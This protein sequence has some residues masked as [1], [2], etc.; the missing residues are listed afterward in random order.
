M[1]PG[2]QMKMNRAP[3]SVTVLAAALR[4]PLMH[5]LLIGG[6]L[7]L[8]YQ[9]H[10]P[11][12]FQ[13]KN[14]ILVT[15]DDVARL[16]AGFAQ[17]WQRKPTSPEMD[18]LI[19]NFVREE[20]YYREAKAMGLDQDDIAVRRRL[21]QKLEFIL[22]DVAGQV[23]PGD[24]QLRAFMALSPQKYMY[25]PR[26]S[27]RQI[28]INPGLHGD[29][30]E[31]DI[32]QLI[33][34]LKSESAGEG[35]Q[36]TEGDPSLLPQMVGNWSRSAVANE[37]GEEFVQALEKMDRGSW[38]GLIHS[39]FGSHLILLLDYRQGHLPE[40]AEIRENVRRDW[41]AEQQKQLAD[42]AYR[43]LRARYRVTIDNVATEHR[44][45]LAGSEAEP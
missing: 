7:F 20:I 39:E 24:D 13:D 29:R 11:V 26:F 34:R 10:N 38:Q 44:V 2:Q 12:V 35:G 9:W 25:E 45:A 27:F 31:Q 15:A 21:R 43:L 4:E 5:F 19:N 42:N 40:L 36:E 32:A 16:A 22:E 6:A 30:L 17:T 8:F 1:K 23:E 18:G 3:L 41:L 33:T 28:Y 37:F 14:D